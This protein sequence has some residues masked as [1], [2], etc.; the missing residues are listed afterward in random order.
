[1]GKRLY[2]RLDL[3][4]DDEAKLCVKGACM[5]FAAFKAALEDRK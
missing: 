1:M 2:R 3:D 4:L 5:T